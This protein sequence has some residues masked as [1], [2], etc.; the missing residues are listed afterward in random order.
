MFDVTIAGDDEPV[1]VA[2]RS[3]ARAIRAETDVRVKL[4]QQLQTERLTGMTMLAWHLA[5]TGQLCAGLEVD[6]VR[7]VL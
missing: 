1:S 7:D 4:W 3:E 2:E 5:D 6:D